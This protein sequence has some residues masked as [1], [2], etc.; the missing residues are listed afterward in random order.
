MK[1]ILCQTNNNGMPGKT[2]N[3]IF[4]SLIL[5]QIFTS[6]LQANE[7]S[8]L[9]YIIDSLEKA[10]WEHDNYDTTRVN[11][12][13]EIAKKYFT[14]DI[15]K[16]KENSETAIAVAESIGYEAGKAKG[17]FLV[18]VYYRI[19]SQYDS[20]YY[21]FESALNIFNEQELAMDAA[22]C[23]IVWGIF[24]LPGESTPGPENI[25]KWQ[26]RFFMRS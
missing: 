3:A 14:T 19:N 22:R 4:L 7:R 6:N 24:P 1:L 13:I 8:N 10:L 15:N 20:A 25:I 26:G 16:L 17:L 5:F 11:L 12:Q 9:P 21:Y 23:I 18:G 2:T